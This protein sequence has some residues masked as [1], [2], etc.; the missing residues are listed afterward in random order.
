MTNGEKPEDIHKRVYNFVV[1]VLKSLTKLPPTPENLVLRRQTAKSVTSIGANGI[2]ADGA[3]S[4]NDF[5]H[6]FTISKKEAKETYYW[7]SLICDHNPNLKEEFYQHLKENN[8]IILII[9][10]IIINAKKNNIKLIIKSD[11]L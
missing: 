7:L 2:E 3:E 5:I 9:S 10:K 1:R 8:E 4:I 6:K 11:K